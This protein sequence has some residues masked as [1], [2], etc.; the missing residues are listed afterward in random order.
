MS[1]FMST[2]FR[3]ALKRPRSAEAD[4]RHDGQT[5]A[6]SWEA[7]LRG[8]RGRCPNCGRGR[9]FPR[10]LKVADLCP[11][12][13]EELFHQRADDFPAYIVIVVVGH[14]V[15]W[16]ALSVQMAF[17]PAMWLQYALWL[18]LTFGLALG[19]V[20]PVKG[21]IIASQ[22]FMGMHGFDRSFARRHGV[23]PDEVDT[24]ITAKHW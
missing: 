23:A 12:C 20:Q 5:Q 15:V 4:E 3:S 8:F 2:A 19:L 11:A 1:T 16:L 21:A 14:I 24:T 22:W 10:F 18:P 7:Y 9:M 17:A 6:S 13:G